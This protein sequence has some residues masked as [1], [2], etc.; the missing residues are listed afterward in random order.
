MKLRLIVPLLFSV[1]AVAAASGPSRAADDTMTGF[2][3][4]A[5]AK[6]CGDG[7]W[8]TWYTIDEHRFDNMGACVTWGRD[9]HVNFGIGP[10]IRLLPKWYAINDPACQIWVAFA[11]RCYGIHLDG[12]GLQPGSTV[13]LTGDSQLGSPTLTTS[14]GLDGNVVPLDYT[15]L[16]SLSGN[17]VATGVSWYGDPVAQTITTFYGCFTDIAIVPVPPD[18][19]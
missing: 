3:A 10:H 16:C 15:F 2:D 13:T 9:N 19:Q 5:A 7:Q 1:I 8:R 4:P 12:K 14:V 18:P 17:W 11:D 6:D